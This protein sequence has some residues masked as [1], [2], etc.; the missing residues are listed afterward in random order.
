[1]NNNI[2]LTI[3]F[4]II[5]NISYSQVGIGTTNPSSKLDIKSS[6]ITNPLST[7]GILI[8]QMDVFPIIN[9]TLA[10]DGML[11]FVTGNGIP[12]KG[13][14]YWSQSTTSWKPIG[15]NSGVKIIDDLLDGK[16]DNDGT[17]NGSSIFL[18]INSGLN[19]DRTNNKNVGIGF[20]VLKANTTGQYNT[21][22]GFHSLFFNTVGS[23]NTAMGVNALY[24]N[25]SGYYN[26]S[27][28]V[29]SLRYNITGAFN[30]AIG[31][32]SLF[33]LT[34]GNKNT[35]NGFEAM[36][37]STAAYRNTVNG[38]RSMYSN[39]TGTYN[40]AL[41]YESGYTNT[42]GN[43]NV[44]LGYNA[45]Y[46]STGSNKLYIENRN[47]NENNALIYGEFGNDATSVGNI[48]RTNSQFQI[49]NPTLTGY[50]FPSSD[51]I[52][53]QV[54]Q[55]N[56]SGLMSWVNSATI[57]T[58]D[59]NLLG[60]TLTGTSLQIDI[61]NGTSTTV[62]LA[63]L[64]DGG[65]QK[66]N[67]LLDGKSNTTGTTVFLGKNAGLNDNGSNS[68][69]NVGIGV[70][71]L[72]TNST[73]FNNVAIGSNA[74]TNATSSGN[75]A[76]GAYSLYF[77]MAAGFQNTAV[78][79]YSLMKNTTGKQNTAVGFESLLSNTSGDANTAIGLHSLYANAIGHGNTAQGLRALYGNYSGNS[80]TALGSLSLQ[81]NIVGNGNTSVGYN[82]LY[83]NYGG[84]Y[85]TAVGMEASS[86]NTNM[87]NTTS[88][89]YQALATANNQVRIGNGFVSSIGGF[90][91]WTNVSDARFKT[92]IKEDV[93]GL[94]FILKLRAVTYNLDLD[95]IEQYLKIP[96]SI[97]N[98]HNGELN[99]YKLYKEKE[100]QSGFI[101]QEVEKA[102]QELNY[103]FSGI[104]KPKNEN[105]YYGLRY[106]EF[107][108]PLVKAVQ[109]QNEIIVKL[110]KENILKTKEISHLTNELE[111]QK[112]RIDKLYQLIEK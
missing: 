109:E 36:F 43:Y 68:N 66:I 51:G 18:G 42:T 6:S 40:T 60:A 101:A 23:N 99:K 105:D 3:F 29:N 41:G 45:G 17:N 16:S 21:G 33:N 35:A 75:T 107:V 30:V 37:S 97:K 44:F 86:F 57:G 91:N 55:T 83:G 106:A 7:D 8:P 111:E 64:Q 48:F 84:S 70:N 88:I 19:D 11:V 108:V 32:K 63:G 39:T 4:F 78:G 5:Y 12:T 89:G 38:Y 50:A 25:S 49:G 104:D 92:N 13:F 93:K 56:G 87:V 94:D 98:G 103:D 81:N 69:Y 80:N 79:N 95:K 73:G 112:D 58:D 74:L 90:A 54:L 27:M 15:G 10:Q 22:N 67:D 59:Q 62:D 34:A 2:L 14:Y 61:E 28:G 52:I 53:G 76:V 96:D 26:T 24:Q 102:A 71:A 20:E 9:P 85:N 65:A 82:S 72:M 47:A 46:N 1:M 110:T 100:K 77:N 31:S